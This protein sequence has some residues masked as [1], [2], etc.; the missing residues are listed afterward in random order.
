VRSV[1]VSL[2]CRAARDRRVPAPPSLL[3]L[4]HR[5][6]TCI[7]AIE[8]AYKDGEGCTRYHPT[9]LAKHKELLPLNSFGTDDDYLQNAQR[10]YSSVIHHSCWLKL[11]IELQASSERSAKGPARLGTPRRPTNR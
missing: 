4:N 5:T 8:A 6:C 11:Q 2:T 9:G 7:E 1:L 10:K 3:R